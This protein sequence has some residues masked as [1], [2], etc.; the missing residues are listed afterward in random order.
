MNVALPEIHTFTF[1][2]GT[3][4]LSPKIVPLTTNFAGSVGLD[5]SELLKPGETVTSATATID[6]TGPPTTNTVTVANDKTTIQVEVAGTI[7]IGKYLLTVTVTPTDAQV[8]DVQGE[9]VV[10][11]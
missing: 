3:H 8:F 6:P 11:A 5:V 2:K 4:L 9:I 10:D 7:S 1:P